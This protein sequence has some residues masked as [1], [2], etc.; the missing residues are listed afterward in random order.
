MKQPYNRIIYCNHQ[1]WGHLIGMIVG[2]VIAIY[3]L[4]YLSIASLP[5]IG[6][7]KAFPLIFIKIIS[8]PFIS[9]MFA[10]IFSNLGSGLDILTNEK[11]IIH[12]ANRALDSEFKN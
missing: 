1:Q 3:S 4:P 8:V 7:V 10:N 5:W 11:T 9:G 6:T 12:F 2:F